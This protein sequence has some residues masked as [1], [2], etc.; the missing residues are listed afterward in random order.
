[1]KSFTFFVLLILVALSFCGVAAAAEVRLDGTQL[2]VAGVEDSIGLGAFTV[3]LE[4]GSDVSVT[5]VNSLSGFMIA[6][7]IRNDKQMTVIGG[8]TGD[9]PGPTG[10][11]AVAEVQT[12]GNGSVSVS[13]IDLTNAN[14]DPI[15]YANPTFT[16]TIPTSDEDV[17]VE[18]TAPVTTATTASS[19]SGQTGTSSGGASATTTEESTVTTE[20]TETGASVTGAPTTT[21]GSEGATTATVAESVTSSVPVGQTTEAKASLSP[22]VAVLALV[23]LCAVHR[24]INMK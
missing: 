24:M 23:S 7:N 22:F 18:T 3:V 17:P 5:S 1:M 6:G 13:V 12:E 11:V 8:I 21:A 16:G 10:D 9:N 20:A 15:S 14:G 19:S 4:Y 2:V